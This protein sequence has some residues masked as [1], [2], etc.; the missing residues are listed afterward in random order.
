MMSLNVRFLIF[1]L[2]LFGLMAISYN[3]QP[4]SQPILRASINKIRA[5]LKQPEQ[6]ASYLT[7]MHKQLP[8]KPFVPPNKEVI[9]TKQRVQ[10]LQEVQK[11][12]EAMHSSGKTQLNL[13][14]PEDWEVYE[15]EKTT[16]YTRYPDFFV[17][18]ERN[19][20]FGVSGALHLDESEAAEE[21]P[22][23]KSILGAEVELKWRLP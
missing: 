21:A 16:E 12:Q 22:L 20:R 6:P 2:I 3:S 19:S 13:S 18:K 8:T 9:A 23:E 7:S 1:L 4:E 15:W 10:E 5:Y 17:P 14:L 11:N